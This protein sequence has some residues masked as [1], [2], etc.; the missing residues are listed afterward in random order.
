MKRLVI[1]CLLLAYSCICKAQNIQTDLIGKKISGYI[2]L[3]ESSKSKQYFLS[4]IIV[5]NTDELNYK[6]KWQGNGDYRIR[7]TYG[8]TDSIV[9]EIHYDWANDKLADLSDRERERLYT[10]L[11]KQ[12]DSLLRKYNEKYGKS[13]PAGEK[14]KLKLGQPNVFNRVNIW[15]TPSGGQI[16]MQLF[17]TNE[18][19]SYEGKEMPPFHRLQVFVKAKP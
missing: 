3:E 9:S 6:S 4:P 7:Y 14:D 2:A 10:I 15:Q 13:K 1:C 8:K 19:W 18:K 16:K 11:Y 12:Y 5:G 17:L